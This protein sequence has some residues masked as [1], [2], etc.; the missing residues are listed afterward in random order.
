M[1]RPRSPAG[2][3]IFPGFHPQPGNSRLPPVWNGK[4]VM[5]FDFE[6]TAAAVEVVIGYDH[7]SAGKYAKEGGDRLLRRLATANE[8]H[9]NP[10]NVLAL[11]IQ[12]CSG[13][14]GTHRR[15]IRTILRGVCPILSAEIG[16]SLFII[17]QARL[18]ALR[19]AMPGLLFDLP[20]RRRQWANPHCGTCRWRGRQSQQFP[21]GLWVGPVNGPA[22]QFPGGF[23]GLVRTSDRVARAR[24]S[25]H[26]AVSSFA[27]MNPGRNIQHSTFNAQPR[28]T[29]GAL[30]VA[31]W[32]LHVEC[33]L[34]FRGSRRGFF[35][36]F[37]S[38]G[39]K[40]RMRSARNHPRLV[41][42]NHPGQ[43]IAKTLRAFLPLRVGGVCGADGER[44]GVRCSSHHL[45]VHGAGGL[46]CPTIFWGS[47]GRR[48]FVP[49]LPPGS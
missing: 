12:E 24:L 42:L 25:S 41:P 48:A 38:L 10:G 8:L 21:S 34:R 4:V 13:Q 31:C 45:R 5:R 19:K 26:R 11:R 22:N 37:F 2:H 47:W 46:S 15:G 3:P 49:P 1:V 44:A 29:G 33:F 40:V 39:E 23:H 36:E 17:S 35:G 20:C 14:I 32:E 27:S 16:F 28:R 18:S 7:V 43:D 6:N 9:N 30:G